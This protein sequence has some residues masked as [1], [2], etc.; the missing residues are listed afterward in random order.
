MWPSVARDTKTLIWKESISKWIASG[1]SRELANDW[2]TKISLLFTEVQVLSPHFSLGSIYW[3]PW[4]PKRH[5]QVHGYV[6]SLTKKKSLITAA[7]SAGVLPLRMVR[8]PQRLS[9]RL[10]N[11][12]QIILCVAITFSSF[13]G[14]HAGLHVDIASDKQLPKLHHF[15]YF[16]LTI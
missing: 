3:C 14:T 5:I 1:T 9:A 7:S 15:R 6:T 13:S 11:P 2:T 8:L 16:K 4:Q 12:F 10:I